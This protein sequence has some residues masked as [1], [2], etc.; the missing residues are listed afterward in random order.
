MMLQGGKHNTSLGGT[1]YVMTSGPNLAVHQAPAARLFAWAITNTS[2]LAQMVGARPACV[3][4][5]VAAQELC[6]GLL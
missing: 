4:A 6:A 1:A 5:D 2:M 3:L